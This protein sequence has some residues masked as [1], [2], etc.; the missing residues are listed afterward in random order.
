MTEIM[1]I[2]SFTQFKR[3]ANI[4][5]RDTL[6]SNR[7]DSLNRLPFVVK[8]NPLLPHISNIL[9]K[10]FNILLS[11]NCCSE[12]FW[13]PPIVAYRRTS[14]LRNI[15]ALS[16]ISKTSLIVSSGFQTRE[17]WWKQEARGRVLL[18]FSSVWN[19]DETRSTS[20]E[21]TSPTKEN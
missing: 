7:Q 8:Y 15:L 10:R 5:H 17:N 9:L 18:L 3:A 16:N 12:V 2:L 21:I 6:N 1:E 19:P 13:E 4:S 14:N 11:S 20:F